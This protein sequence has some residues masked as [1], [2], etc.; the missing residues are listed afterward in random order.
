MARPTPALAAA[1]TTIVLA[2]CGS[3]DG[4]TS[5]D[6]DPAATPPPTPATNLGTGPATCVS[7]TADGYD[8]NGISL[9]RNVSL[10]DLGGESGSD[11]WGWV[12][13][14]DDTEYV[15]MGLNNGTAFVRIA[16]PEAPEVVGHLPTETASSSWRDIKVYEDHAY[17]V[18]DS[19]DDHGMQV[20]DLTRLRAGGTGQ[21]FS[22]DVI[23]GDIRSAHNVAINVSTG[24]GYV[25]GS[26]T[27]AGGLHQV[28]LNPP[29]NP[30]FA[31]CHSADGYTH[32]ADCV[33]Y[34][35]PDTDHAGAEICFNAN[36]DHVAIV[37]VSV[38]PSP[39]TLS[40]L[41]YPDAAY[42][43]QAIPDPTHRYVLV[44]D[45]NDENQTG[46]GT[47]TIVLDVTDL[48]SPDYLYTHRLTTGTT[49]HNL[50]V[51]GSRVY[52]ANYQSGLRVLEYTDL[53]T[54]TLNEIAHFDTY[55]EG[56]GTSTRGAWGV[57]ARFPSGTIAVSDTERG[58]Y[59]F[60]LD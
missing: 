32:D 50:M 55:P 8:C 60:T 20:F 30:T 18:A 9:A 44:G 51:D 42:V 59:L 17:I 26:G 16:D 5:P 34:S 56:D 4:G 24:L 39:V 36:E 3:G 49:D 19:A 14:S 38:K 28:D 58:L 25:V 1:V 35:G 54:D 31:G 21:T 29:I 23:Y 52:E 57:Y 48:D 7:G 15:L 22:A 46:R 13:P 43:H 53:A 33:S 2:A 11:I 12:D 10:A 27:C 45:E 47:G 6:G 40:T 37:D 41:V